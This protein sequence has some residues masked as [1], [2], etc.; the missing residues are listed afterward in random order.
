MIR[1]IE[2]FYD[3][4]SYMIDL[5]REMEDGEAT[6]TSM[7]LKE[8]YGGDDLDEGDLMDIHS[9]LFTVAKANG[10]EL[11]MSAHLGKLEGLPYNL[12]F[13]V[14]NKNAQIKCPHCGS[15]NTARVLHG[16]PVFSDELEKKL[17]SGKVVL[18]GCMVTAVKAGGYDVIIN[19]D[20]RCNDCKEDFATPPVLLAE[21]GRS[22][23]LYRDIVESI[24]FS[25]G[26]YFDG[27]TTTTIRKE[28]NTASVTIEYTLGEGISKKFEIAGDKWYEIIESLYSK[29]Y[30]HEWEKSY[31]DPFV[32][33]GEQWSLTI[34]LTDNRSIEYE[35]SNAYPPYWDEL[36]ELFAEVS[37][38]N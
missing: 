12:D 10:I 38:D 9:E 33:D 36:M 22:G 5:L 7:L 14:H 27:Y 24:E 26:G 15:T 3:E 32:L 35:G 25:D 17:N 8:A 34:R 20:R 13:V 1:T 28:G 37:S 18:G 19:A 2:K 6:T 4:I 30:I 21:D 16:M 31:V 11:D 29:M 23:E